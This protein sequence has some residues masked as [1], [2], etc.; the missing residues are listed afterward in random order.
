MKF[1]ELREHH[2]TYKLLDCGAGP[3]SFAAEQTA[4]GW[5]VTAVDPTYALDETEI[6]A[7][8]RG[9]V[10][11]MRGIMVDEKDRF[12]WD[13]YGDVDRVM[14]LRQEALDLFL[15]DYEEG[16]RCGRYRAGAL[17]VLD[18]APRTF[19]LALCSHLLFIYSDYL[20]LEFHL[21]A[22]IELG[23][24]AKETRVFPLMNIDGQRSPYVS[25]VLDRLGDAGLDASLEPVDFEF[26]KGATSMLVV[27]DNRSP[28]C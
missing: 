17:P 19:D 25:A 10:E 6:R 14:K 5:D 15:S 28:D 8:V 3:S 27:R 2:A 18:F 23:R 20:D 13:F 22:L 16:K 1:F 26:Q 11:W 4:L 9:G 7:S 12:C 24:V 21:R